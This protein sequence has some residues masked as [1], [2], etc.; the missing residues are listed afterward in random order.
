MIP[1]QIG[2][3]TIVASTGRSAMS[4]TEDPSIL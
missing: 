1:G 3:L 4:G 2:T